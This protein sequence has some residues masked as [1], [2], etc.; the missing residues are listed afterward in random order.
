MMEWLGVIVMVLALI[1]IPLGLPGLWI[2]IAIG[3]LLST[4]RGLRRC[5]PA[6]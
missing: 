5:G 1:S 4:G 3:S 2:M 6:R